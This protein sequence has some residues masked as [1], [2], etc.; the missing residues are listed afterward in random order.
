M[1]VSEARQAVD[2]SSNL[3]ISSREGDR[4]N[5][6]I[7]GLLRPEAAMDGVKDGVRGRVGKAGVSHHRESLGNCSAICKSKSACATVVA[8]HVGRGTFQKRVPR[9]EE[10]LGCGEVGWPEMVPSFFDR[11]GH[12][13]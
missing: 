12:L 9:H 6:D 4:L 3:G 11:G 8:E 2:N 5:T 13:A 1:Q 10:G 7:E